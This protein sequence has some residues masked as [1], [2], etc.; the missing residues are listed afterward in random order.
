MYRLSP[1]TYMLARRL[2]KLPHF[3]LVNIVAGERL[4]PELIQH[5]VNGERIAKEVRALLAH[6]DEVVAGLA[7]V[8]ERLGGLG[9]S[10][11]AAEEIFRMLAVPR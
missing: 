6:Y 2:V 10:R 4:V 8:R 1:A 3:S 9:A 7:V 5:D 11:R